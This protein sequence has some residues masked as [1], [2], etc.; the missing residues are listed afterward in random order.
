MTAKRFHKLFGALMSQIMKGNKGAGRCIKAARHATP[1]WK[2]L[3]YTNY[4]EAWDS[5][6]KVEARFPNQYPVVS[7]DLAKSKI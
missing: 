1:N 4:Q 6:C 2:T 7:Q 5:L 3:G